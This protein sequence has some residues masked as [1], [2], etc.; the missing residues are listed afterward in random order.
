[1]AKK[2]LNEVNINGSRVYVENGKVKTQLSEE[3]QKNGYMTV[4]DAENI[5]HA[6]VNNLETIYNGK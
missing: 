6:F 3:I 2:Q 5:L 1:M 4:E